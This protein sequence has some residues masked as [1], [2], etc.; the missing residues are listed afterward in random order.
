MATKIKYAANEALKV[1]NGPLFSEL[2]MHCFDEPTRTKAHL[3]AV[4]GR[5]GKQFGI[6]LGNTDVMTGNHP[7][8]QTRILLEKFISPNIPGIELCTFPYQGSRI[9]NNK[10]SKIAAINQ[11]SCIVADEVALKTLLRWYAGNR[12]KQI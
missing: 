2:S 11:I 7:A 5:F 3:F 6:V 1:I 12:Y 9:K 4:G 10:D 8:R